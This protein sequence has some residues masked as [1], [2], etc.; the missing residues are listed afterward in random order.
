MELSKNSWHVWVYKMTY[1][2]YKLPHNLCPYFWKLLL[3]LITFPVNAV[4][5]GPAY[6]KSFSLN[7]K[8]YKDGF[9]GGGN[10]AK[11]FAFNII[12]SVITSMVL[13]WFRDNE[14][15]IAAGIVGYTVVGF[16]LLCIGVNK[17]SKKY[18]KKEKVKKPNVFIEF[19]KATYRKNCPMLMWKD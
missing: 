8:W 11:G 2:Y 14:A 10:Y 6:I 4:W 9:W 17:Y 1:G 7:Q 19:I 18:P 12:L 16:I 5:T 3:A 15:I 13:M